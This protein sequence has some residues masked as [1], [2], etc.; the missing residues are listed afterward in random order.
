MGTSLPYGYLLFKQLQR[1][2]RN[3]RKQRSEMRYV[4]LSG[5]RS[6]PG[7]FRP[8]GEGGAGRG[9]DRRGGGGGKKGKK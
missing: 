8:L 4:P 6:P 3:D 2:A 5:L 1:A 7:G 9:E